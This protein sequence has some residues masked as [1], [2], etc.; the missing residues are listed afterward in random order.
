VDK[1]DVYAR[2]LVQK[3]GAKPV[4]YEYAQSLHAEPKEMFVFTFTKADD[5]GGYAILT[6]YETQ[7]V[8]RCH[9]LNKKDATTG[10][11]RQMFELLL[12]KSP[13]FKQYMNSV[14][15]KRNGKFW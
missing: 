3:R 15:T 12:Q 10:A 2:E 7:L 11:F 6:E 13:K 4:L 14:S 1:I 8:C 9:G 5:V